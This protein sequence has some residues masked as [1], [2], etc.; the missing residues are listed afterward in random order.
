M[1]VVSEKEYSI[2]LD[3]LYDAIECVKNAHIIGCEENY[4]GYRE[5]ANELRKIWEKYKP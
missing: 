1:R 2:I 5:E 4:C 3:A